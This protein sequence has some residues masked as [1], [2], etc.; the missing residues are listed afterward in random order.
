MKRLIVTVILICS[1]VAVADT[2]A[3]DRGDIGVG[4]EYT[5]EY[6]VCGAPIGG[7]G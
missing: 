2:A 4:R 7:C 5:G 3:K 1:C 6:G